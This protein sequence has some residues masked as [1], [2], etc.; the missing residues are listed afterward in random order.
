MVT[1]LFMVDGR[2]EVVFFREKSGSG[3][4]RR[5]R[6]R[7]PPARLA[8]APTARKPKQSKAAKGAIAWHCEGMIDI[9]KVPVLNNSEA[10]YQCVV[11]TIIIRA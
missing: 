2:M 3:W 8:S 10:Y 5:A 4:V 1:T 9:I 11:V 6:R 7:W